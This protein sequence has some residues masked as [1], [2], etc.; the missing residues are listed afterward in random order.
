M[1]RCQGRVPHEPILVTKKDY[2]TLPRQSIRKR[3]GATTEENES[4]VVKLKVTKPR[5]TA[6]DGSLPHCE[7]GYGTT[8]FN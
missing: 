7:T 5:S 8:Y 6:T 2:W 1:D 4:L 3:K